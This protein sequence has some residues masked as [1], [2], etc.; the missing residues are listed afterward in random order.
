MAADPVRRP[1]IISFIRNFL[2]NETAGGNIL[3]AVAALALIVANSAAGPAYFAIL[4][5]KYFGLSVL[6][7]IND[8]LMAVFSC[9]SGLKSNANLSTANCRPGISGRCLRLLRS[10]A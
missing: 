5:Q 1:R 2:D 4:E 6:H 7:W 9:W 3:M 10:A 8:A